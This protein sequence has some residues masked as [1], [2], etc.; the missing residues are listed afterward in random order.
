[1][2]VGKAR[3]GGFR[4]TVGLDKFPRRKLERG[5]APA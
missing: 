4:G 2:L 1:M 3:R 5:F